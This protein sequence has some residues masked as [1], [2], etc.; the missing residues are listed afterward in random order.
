MTHPPATITTEAHPKIHGTWDI[1]VF[2]ID[3]F[4]IGGQEVAERV[5]DGY[6]I[7]TF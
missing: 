2:P 1:L 6:L 5:K 4:V 3:K 7:M